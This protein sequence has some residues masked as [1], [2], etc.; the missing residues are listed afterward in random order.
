MGPR[1]LW[2]SVRLECGVI[3]LLPCFIVVLFLDLKFYRE[4]IY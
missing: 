4:R 2:F 3:F 1:R